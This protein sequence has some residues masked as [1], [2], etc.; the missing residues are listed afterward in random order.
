MSIV[1]RLTGKEI[2]FAIAGEE[3]GLRWSSPSVCLNPRAIC[4]VY[5]A[6]PEPNGIRTQCGVGKFEHNGA[7]ICICKKI[8]PREL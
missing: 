6:M 8:D 1:F 2:S 3:D 7:D 4:A 5:G